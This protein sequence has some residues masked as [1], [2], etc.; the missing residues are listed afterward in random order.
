MDQVDSNYRDNDPIFNIFNTNL[1]RILTKPLLNTNLT[2]TD[3][4][5]PIAMTSP[6]VS[7]ISHYYIK[8]K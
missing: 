7:Q 3:K 8:C 6:K 1:V 5:V 2:L 4:V